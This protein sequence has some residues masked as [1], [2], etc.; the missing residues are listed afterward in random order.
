MQW[1][2][3]P[4][5]SAAS[6]Y[7]QI[8]NNFYCRAIDTFAV[9]KIGVPLEINEWSSLVS[10]RGRDQ[11]AHFLEVLFSNCHKKLYNS[12][13]SL[14]TVTKMQ[15]NWVATV[16]QNF[17]KVHLQILK[18]KENSR[19]FSD[20]LGMKAIHITLLI[21]LYYIGYRDFLFPYSFCHIFISIKLCLSAFI[22]GG[23]VIL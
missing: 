1:L 10:F 6:S 19:Y 13:C 12:N 5:S 14:A 21:K 22:Y 15:W 4:I 2:W 11:G 20:G 16:Q 18:V 8:S 9:K 23:C 17:V 3:I 7:R